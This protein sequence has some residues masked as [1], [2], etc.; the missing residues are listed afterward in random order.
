[1]FSKSLLLQLPDFH[2]LPTGQT[3]LHVGCTHQWP[4]VPQALIERL[5][6]IFLISANGNS[7]LPGLNKQ[8]KIS[9][10]SGSSLILYIP[11]SSSHSYLTLVYFLVSNTLLAQESL[12]IHCFSSSSDIH[13]L[14][15]IFFRYILKCSIIKKVFLDHLL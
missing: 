15:P 10:F 14:L 6:Y 1:M 4:K 11:L 5:S 3:H 8:A 2:L 7:R 12:L 13:T 9:I